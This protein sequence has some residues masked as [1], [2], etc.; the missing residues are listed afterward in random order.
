MSLCGRRLRE[1]VN[2]EQAKS[3]FF[4]SFKTSLASSCAKRLGSETNQLPPLFS[5]ENYSTDN[6]LGFTPRSAAAVM[7]MQGAD[8]LVRSTIFFVSGDRQE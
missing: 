1:T 3:K 7:V 8:S 4:E 2:H 6:A 5:R